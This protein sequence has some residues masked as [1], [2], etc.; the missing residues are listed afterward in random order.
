M[1]RA[2]GPFL[3]A[4]GCAMAE[5]KGMQHSMFVDPAAAR[6]PEYRQFWQELVRGEQKVAEF[7][8]FARGG[9]PACMQASDCP[10]FGR[11]GRL[12]R[13][14]KT[15]QDMADKR[16][17]EADFE[18]RVEASNPSQTV[19]RWL[20]AVPVT[21]TRRFG[22]AAKPMLQPQQHCRASA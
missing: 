6:G 19:I 3:A 10:V 16:L 18:S 7:L 22:S 5:I 12:T 21:L 1:L 15:V 8:R 14:I 20:T 4:M 11:F 2:N 13:V 9:K 17:R